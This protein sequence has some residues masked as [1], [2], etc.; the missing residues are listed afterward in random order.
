MQIRS[1]LTLAALAAVSL[2]GC[3]QLED[4]RVSAPAW[5]SGYSWTYKTQTEFIEGGELGDDHDMAFEETL[6]VLRHSDMVAGKPFYIV[7]ESTG[8]LGGVDV[9]DDAGEEV[10]FDEG[11][12]ALLG[13]SSVDLSSYWIQDQVIYDCD[14]PPACLADLDLS[15]GSDGWPFPALQFPLT[16]AKTWTDSLDEYVELRAEVLGSERISTT[17]GEFDAIRVLFSGNIR[18]TETWDDETES[19]D[20]QLSWDLYYSSEARAVVRD[21]LRGVGTIVETNTDGFRKTHTI[22]VTTSRELTSYS[23]VAAPEM[24]P[25]ELWDHM[26]GDRFVQR[27]VSIRQDTFP[28]AGT[29]MAEVDFRASEY[30]L[31]NETLVWSVVDAAGVDHGTAEGK[32]FTAEVPYGGAYEVRLEAMRGERSVAAD[33]RYFSLDEADAV[34]L[35]CG[36]RIAGTGGGCAETEVEV[37]PGAFELR[38]DADESSVLPSGGTIQLVAPDG[39]VVDDDNV[40]LGPGDLGT[41]TIRYVFEQG[42]AVNVELEWEVRYDAWSAFMAHETV[43]MW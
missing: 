6:R 28:V 43:E 25:E 26:D 21:E 35:D 8:P 30:G 38:V 14:G 39:T 42:V 20:I 29:G 2:S 31:S 5:E 34:S 10:Y 40:D 23:L 37:K 1:I 36:T 9:G 15:E 13:I 7:E 3:A 41:W 17:A 33:S 16:D 19:F 11:W 27:H 24:S 18:E 4:F 32:W 22:D 12:S